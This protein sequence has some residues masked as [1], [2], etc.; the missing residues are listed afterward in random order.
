MLI[1][2]PR[3]KRETGIVVQEQH[4]LV[5]LGSKVIEPNS[6]VIRYLCPECSY[7]LIQGDLEDE[8]LTALKEVKC[9]QIW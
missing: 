4:C 3:C 6:I 2:C 8:K 1:V 7:P 9:Q 5:D